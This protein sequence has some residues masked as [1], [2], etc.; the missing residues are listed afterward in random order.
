[1][2]ID[3]DVNSVT[4][5]QISLDIPEGGIEAPVTRGQKLGE[6]SII[7]NGKSYG[8]FSLVANSRVELART[9]Y[10]LTRVKET[11]SQTWV[12]ITIIVVILLAA[13]YFYVAFQR[14]KRNQKKRK[15]LANKKQERIVYQDDD[16]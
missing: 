7:Y 4:A 13:L 1:M 10:L 5:R 11:L 9:A 14:Y 15:A 12:R 6:I 8:P 16:E 3:T 2:P